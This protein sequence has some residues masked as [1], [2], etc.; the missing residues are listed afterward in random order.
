MNGLTAGELARYTNARLHADLTVVPMSG[1]TRAM[2]WPQTGRES[3]PPSPNLR[4]ADAA[5]LYP[6]TGLIE[7]TNVSEGRGTD[8][9]F[10]TICAP[11]PRS[12][13]D[14][15]KAPWR[16]AAPDHCRLQKTDKFARTSCRGV[17]LDVS[18]PSAVDGYRISLEPAARAAALA[19]V[20]VVGR[21]RP[22]AAC[23]DR[24]RREHPGDPH[25]RRPRRR[26]LAQGSRPYLLYE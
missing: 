14:S 8:A 18:D 9:P 24:P 2:T 4:S 17:H 7:S 5:L 11:W 1:W 13:D 21:D 26:G 6:G 3:V 20:R 15:A 19:A 25:R 16:H 22:A 23:G 10:Q 12:R